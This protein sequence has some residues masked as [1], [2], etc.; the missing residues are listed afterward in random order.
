VGQQ[1]PILAAAGADAT[2]FDNS[3]R[4]LQQDC[5]VAEREGL[6]LRTVEGD[7]RD[8]SCFMATKAHK[9]IAG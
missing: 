7:M 9:S 6:D 8:L 3:P 2:V 5:Q 4:Q 1:G